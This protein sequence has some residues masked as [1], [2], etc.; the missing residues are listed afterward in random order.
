L[1]FEIAGFKIKTLKRRCGR[2]DLVFGMG[3]A[4]SLMAAKRYI[5]SQ[6]FNIVSCT[7]SLVMWV[8]LTVQNPS[9]FNY[10]VIAAYNLFRVTQAA[11]LWTRTYFEI[12]KTM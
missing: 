2:D 1:L 5:D 8:L 10:V 7:I 3:V 4:I 12:K 11:V 9:N 6:Y